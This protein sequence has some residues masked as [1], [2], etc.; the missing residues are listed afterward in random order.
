[1]ATPPQNSRSCIAAEHTQLANVMIDH[2]GSLDIHVEVYRSTADKRWCEFIAVSLDT[3]EQWRVES[4]DLYGAACVLA[5]QVG[6]D[7]E[8]G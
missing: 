2:I 6:I 8:D 3:C 7:L 5:E 4:D 1:M